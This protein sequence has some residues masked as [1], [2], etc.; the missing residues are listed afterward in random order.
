LFPPIGPSPAT[1]YADVNNLLGN[2]ITNG[3]TGTN[4]INFTLG[5]GVNSTGFEFVDQFT[6]VIGGS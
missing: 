1:V 4:S 3:S 6:P 5:A 2:N